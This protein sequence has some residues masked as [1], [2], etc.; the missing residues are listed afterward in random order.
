LAPPYKDEEAIKAELRALTAKTRK[1]REELRGM[2]SAPSSDI[3]RA[4]RHT[5]SW[6]RDRR[7]NAAPVATDR[8]KSKNRS[9][10]RS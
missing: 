4:L 9:R 7:T 2:V 8:R 5:Q 1:L 3:T 6:P 10:S